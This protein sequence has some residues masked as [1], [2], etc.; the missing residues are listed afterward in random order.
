MSTVAEMSEKAPFAPGGAGAI[1]SSLPRFAD[2]AL[3]GGRAANILA[4]TR[5][6][7]VPSSIC[8]KR[9]LKIQKH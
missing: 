7:R 5:G 8:V 1:P 6:S 4:A 3:P 9:L 2:A